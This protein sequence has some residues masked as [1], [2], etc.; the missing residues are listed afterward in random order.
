MTDSVTDG[1]AA[2]GIGIDSVGID[3]SDTDSSD[4]DSDVGSEVVT[5]AGPTVV[6][7]APADGATFNVGES[8]HFEVSVDDDFDSE[9]DIGWASSVVTDPL[10][11]GK[12]TAGGKAVLDIATLPAGKQTITVGVKDS[13]DATGTASIEI[14]VNT[15]PGAPKIEISPAKPTTND[16]LVA[17]IEGVAVDV[18]R[19]S[20]ELTYTYL[21]LVDGK[22]TANVEATLP[23]GTAKKGE[24]WAVEV[25]AKDPYTTGPAG[26][27]TVLIGN[28][29]PAGAAAAIAPAPI[30]L[31]SEVT[32]TL[33]KEAVD[34]DGDG[35]TYTFTWQVNGDIDLADEATASMLRIGDLHRKD[36]SLAQVGDTIACLIV[37]HDA[38]S[39]AA[40]AASA[41]LTVGAFDVCASDLS[42]C[43]SNANCTDTKT[44]IP[45]CACKAG[46]VGDGANCANIDECGDGSAV[47]DLA[48][49]CTD[50]VGSY[51]CTCNNG[52]AGD[53]KTC[54]DVDECGDGTAVCD[55]AASC[56]NT[57]GSYECSCLPGYSGDGK[58]CTD[59]DECG[60]G[61]AVC[62]LAASCTNTVGSYKCECM[63]GYSGDGKTCKDIDEC[64]NGTAGCAALATCTNVPGSFMC[65]CKP[66]YG[67]DGKTCSDIDECKN[68]LGGGAF[69]VPVGLTDWGVT[70]TSATVGWSSDGKQLIYNDPKVG[71]YAGNGSNAG[72]ATS[73]PFVVPSV[74]SVALAF[75]ATLAVE[76]SN[77]YDKFTISV[78]EGET[79]TELINKAGI[80]VAK[81]VKGQVSLAK[82]AGKTISLRFSF[83][84]VDSISN[85]TAGVLIGG[86]AL[87]ADAC[88]ADATC[89]NSTG[90]YS[91]ACN[92]GFK[93][94]G[95]VC[96]DINEC[97]VDNGGCD[98]NAK[99]TNA[100]GSSS[101]AC[102]PFWSGD[103]KTCTDVD[104]CAKDN[105]GCGLPGAYSCKNNVGAPPT[106]ADIDEC[107]AGTA[108]CDSKASCINTVGNYLCACN[109]GYSGNGK[110][111]TDID[112][113]KVGV[114]L[115][116]SV[117]PTF[118]EWA[119]KNSD[120]TTGWRIEGET[121]VYNNKATGDYKGAGANKGT[122]TMPSLNVQS[123]GTK[124][125][126]LAMLAIETDNG[127]D[128]FNVELVVE[129]K[130][131]EL[132][133]K[134]KLAV[135][136][137]APPVVISFDDYIGK[138][139]QLQFS[140]DTVDAS[141]NETA[142]IVLSQILFIQAGPVCDANATCGNTAG[143]FTCECNT[144]FAGDGK[145]C[146][147]VD[148]CQ[149]DN[150]GCGLPDAMTCTNNEGAPPTCN[151]V[152]ECAMG[153][154]ACDI[155][156]SCT[157]TVGD[158]KCACNDYY[159]GDGKSCS[160]V[161]ECG[162]DNGGCGLPGAFTCTNNEGAPP[163]CKDIDE[164][165]AG[166]DDCAATATCSN[167]DG[168]FTCKCKDGYSGDG[169]TC[170]DI[171]ECLVA[172]GGCDVNAKCTNKIAAPPTCA[173]N[174]GYAGNGK[175]CVKTQPAGTCVGHCGGQAIGCWCDSACSGMGDCCGDFNSVCK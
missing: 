169:K 164:C 168:S 153:T 160:D 150:G 56:T 111:C 48:A 94:D 36:G 31:A 7:V 45:T 18:D 43:A 35:V 63:P 70:G 17:K 62:D 2:D 51:T 46:F 84:T 40:A 152:D 10:K 103:G 69:A 28:A 139:V 32:C 41:A 135:G 86:L 113:C 106:C 59:I 121:M 12:A 1:I 77:S 52:Y 119:I 151:D 79:V 60:A 123:L 170:A 157:N 89:T 175:I 85:A 67:G 53:G 147:D 14:W 116:N 93:G 91:C 97:L 34:G 115:S 127:F 102:A 22:A 118:P 144:Y 20:T 131:I 6:F 38:D 55:L 54:K 167:T 149:T 155:A 81:A 87:V 173:C 44:L 126:F 129:G 166:T 154:D 74:G 64:S 80:G 101:C 82:W 50:T 29:V 49:T 72:S 98:K 66:G 78:I 71:N 146:D 83:D 8:I 105:G 61:T 125:S 134:S 37:A 24:S 148:E 117:T 124:I 172:N 75:E 141:A 158:Y 138:T 161:N 27:A 145:Y 4:T 42:P 25:K 5:N 92:S 120:Q 136:K 65:A 11:V 13:G 128:K 76:S 107:G 90:S 68:G 162:T 57:V 171:D 165:E 122:L 26:K 95:K 15:A 108:V 23:A 16:I 137:S 143:S 156:A 47:C 96:D 174:T 30:T 142:G 9:L 58:S 33:A 99:C 100:P 114:E 133:D 140:F 73:P 109:D 110:T 132:M 19:A 159:E 112:E 21:W 88:D 3:S 130:T 163:L 104:E 39:A